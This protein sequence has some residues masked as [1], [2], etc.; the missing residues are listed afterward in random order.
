MKLFGYNIEFRRESSYENIENNG[1]QLTIVGSLG[2]SNNVTVRTSDM[3]EAIAAANR[4]IDIIANSVAATPINYMKKKD[5]VFIIDDSH[6]LQ[7]LL[8]IEPQLEYSAFSFW[9]AAVRQMI[10]EGNAYIIPRTMFGDTFR[11][12][13][14]YEGTGDH[15]ELVLL[16]SNTVSQD[17]YNGIYT[18]SDIENGVGGTFHERDIIHLYMREGTFHEG[19]RL[20][21]YAQQVLSIAATGDKE[22][23]DRFG[24]GGNV[25]GLV[26]NDLSAQGFGEYQE[27]QLKGVAQS[28]GAR[29]RTDRFLSVPGQV[30]VDTIT[31]DSAAM[32][33]LES[34]KYGTLDICRMFGVPPTFVYA[35][36]SNNY[37]SVEMASTDF[38]NQTLNPIFEMVESEMHRKLIMRRDWMRKKIEF[39]R[40][41]VWRLD[42][43]TQLE[44]D[45]RMLEMGL[46]TPNE[47]RHKWNLLEI[48]GGDK[49]LVSANLAP[50]DSPKLSGMPVGGTSQEK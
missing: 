49:T 18:V 14:V 23:L 22:T 29:V 43:T 46:M 34:R 24:S 47:L 17:S 15:D 4:C 38:L 16:R 9:K 6:P 27:D 48:K 28:L 45:K 3:V 11:Y 10:I 41:Q 36:T 50:I 7:T 13:A 21:N 25:R 5:S 2:E 35:D 26:S 19:M 12:G 32:Q 40:Q 33:F 8:R 20:L 31:L 44:N 37:K 1:A 42:I 30:K 39:D